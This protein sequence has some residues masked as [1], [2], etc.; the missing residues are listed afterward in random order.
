MFKLKTAMLTLALVT[1]LMAG[2]AVA[3][4]KPGNGGGSKSSSGG[5]KASSSHVQK[6]SNSSYAQSSKASEVKNNTKSTKDSQSKSGKPAIVNHTQA[7]KTVKNFK[8]TNKHWAE[9]PIQ[10]LQ[11]LG[12]VS[13]FPDGGFHPEDPVTEEQVIAM[14]M[15]ALDTDVT[16]DETNDEITT[17]TDVTTETVSTATEPTEG[18]EATLEDEVTDELGDVP[19]WAEKAVQ[20]AKA[21]G[22]INRFH[23]G[24]QASRAQSMVMVAKAM[25]LEPADTTNM[26]FKDGLQVNQEDLGYIMALYNK[27][28]VK[29]GPGGMLNPNSSITRA[30]IAALLDRVLTKEEDQEVNAFQE[31]TTVDGNQ[32]IEIGTG[33]NATEVTLAE[34]A[35][36]FVNGQKA[37][38][39]D[40]VAGS[41]IRVV[42]NEAGEA[43]LVE[44][45]VE[46][47]TDTTTTDETATDTTNTNS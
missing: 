15:S 31:V 37:E 24:V 16:I 41:P 36:I 20:K 17:T 32:V 23:S 4:A 39:S 1:Y 2:A 3:D 46:A 11:L 35:V 38:V 8:D 43:V 42:T 5:G 14:V 30:Q 18:E 13:G 34:D 47:N 45:T 25:G 22:V 33:E 26:P 28:I 12:V 40:L 21:K 7:K 29:G 6:S 44:Q 10:R 19:D 27:G 9:V